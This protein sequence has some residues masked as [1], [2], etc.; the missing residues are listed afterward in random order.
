MSE[1]DALFDEIQRFARKQLEP[2]SL[3][4]SSVL[5]PMLARVFAIEQTDLRR[6]FAALDLVL[7][8]AVNTTP[9]AAAGGDLI[10]HPVYEV[11]REKRLRRA[12]QRIRVSSRTAR[13]HEQRMM[14]ELAQG[15]WSVL[16]DP[17]QVASIRT[18]LAASPLAQVHEGR[19]GSSELGL[20]NDEARESRAVPLDQ[21]WWNA[22]RG[23]TLADQDFLFTGR[24]K[25]LGDLASFAG[26]HR[27]GLA[28][29]TGMPGAG[30]SAVL[31][32]LVTRARTPGR[33]PADALGTIPKLDVAAALHARDK[34]AEELVA[35]LADVLTTGADQ[36]ASGAVRAPVM[37]TLERSPRAPLLLVVDA[38]D[39][40]PD[41]DAVMTL[42]QDLARRARV[43]VGV[44]PVDARSD[45]GSPTPKALRTLHPLVIDLDSDA[46]RT[47]DDVA[48]YVA[49]RLITDERPNGYGAAGWTSRLLF[50]EI[51][52]EVG[53]AANRNF[54]VAQFMT[55]ELLDRRPLDD[56]E[57]GWS[58]DLQWPSRIDDWMRRDL[59]RRIP[60]DRRHLREVLRPLGFA[61]RGGLPVDIW[62][63]AA[64][65]FRE[66]PTGPAD[67]GEVVERLGF[68]LVVSGGSSPRFSFRH[69]SFA[70]YFRSGALQTVY[71]RRMYEAVLAAVPTE[72]GSR[73]WDRAPT[74]VQQNLLLHARAADALD[75]LITE[76]PLSLA[77]VAVD[78]AVLPL[79]E[80]ATPTATRVATV[81]RQA[82]YSATEP[83]PQRAAALQF[84][85]TLLGAGDL[86]TRLAC[87]PTPLPWYSPWRAGGLPAAVPVSAATQTWWLRPVRV[88]DRDAV[89]IVDASGICTVRDA[90]TQVPLGPGIDVSDAGRPPESLAAW[91]G[92]S[93]EVH[94]ASTRELGQVSVWLATG[95]DAALAP[96]VDLHPGAAVRHLV[97]VHGPRGV[98]LVWLAAGNPAEVTIWPAGRAVADSP[99]FEP[100]VHSADDALP[101][102]ASGESGGAVTIMRDGTLT[103]WTFTADA[104]PAV[105]QL[106]AP[107]RST[108]GALAAGSSADLVVVTDHG[109]ALVVHRW[110]EAR[111]QNPV[112]VGV[113]GPL[114]RF[115]LRITSDGVVRLAAGDSDGTVN[116]WTVRP[117]EPARARSTAETGEAV[118][119]LTFLDGEGLVLAV[120]G[121][122]GVVRVLRDDNSSELLPVAL[123]NH[124]EPLSELVR[125]GGDDE[126]PLVATRGLAGLTK[127]WQ[128]A[129]TGATRSDDAASDLSL[130]RS[131]SS[132]PLSARTDVVATATADRTAIDVW[133]IDPE[134]SEAPRVQLVLDCEE[135]PDVI[136]LTAVTGG[137]AVLCAVG[138]ETISAWRIDQDVRA[139]DRWEAPTGEEP[140]EHLAVLAGSR[141]AAVV[142]AA[143][144]D[145]LHTAILRPGRGMVRSVVLAETPVTALTTCPDPA[146][147][148][149]D[150]VLAGTDDGELHV[151]PVGAHGAGPVH[152]LQHP[153]P[154]VHVVAL[155][156]SMRPDGRQAAISI[157][158]SGTIAVWDVTG[159]SGTPWRS[160]RH[161]TEIVLACAVQHGREPL[162]GVVDLT[163]SFQLWDVL[164]PEQPRLVL[165]EPGLGGRASH[166]ISTP[167]D[168]QHSMVCIGYTT[169]RIRIV[170]LTDLTSVVADLNCDVSAFAFALRQGWVIGT[171][172]A[173]LF[174]ITVRLRGDECV[175][176]RAG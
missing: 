39:E 12:G 174:A 56:I 45:G 147:D 148:D 31:G 160:F 43:I 24:G 116:L 75:D 59:D 165:H 4:D 54:L 25:V 176:D 132:A 82:A 167:P 135:Q 93:G 145:G 162:L 157:G 40:S 108:R 155:R 35:E 7:R 89:A 98:D 137:G 36:A 161:I 34:T 141:T 17:E 129:A 18:Q 111:S 20:V 168:A 87:V 142:V 146:R 153:E 71:A 95:P 122:G 125:L 1:R 115:A 101:V 79:R 62:Q 22:A 128:L 28:V 69:E 60:E 105:E 149:G 32:A 104:E 150:L 11:S 42:V 23:S 53:R 10:G 164:S 64:T 114:V 91:T 138:D 73:R 92:A 85:A 121:W 117:G 14:E 119:A 144:P 58:R 48:A 109:D 76:E 16:D 170:D 47:V 51:G 80:V 38:L 151:V 173:A 86:A 103:L 84:H 55:E 19:R 158:R 15:V 94:V 136:A 67:V 130:I 126:R 5:A 100:H 6:Q 29:V 9:H 124:G 57:R 37:E 83:F 120:A 90:A 81:F 133:V 139:A 131:M 123:L 8:S 41:S 96:M 27:P 52:H 21:H 44:R 68:F 107:G 49:R 50:A 159:S 77:A 172:G 30:K 74:Y 110:L 13:R 166:L 112:E 113:G 99:L 140:F 2:A 97:P 169:G 175:G 134:S 143:G 127:F 78:S 102:G 63:T 66:S 118:R 70:E 26:R 88:E 171:F 61:E 33:L 65:L 163:G 106:V 3:R 154:I 156:W 152:V 72:S 46:Y